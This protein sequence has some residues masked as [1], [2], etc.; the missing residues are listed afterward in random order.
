M[1]G[2]AA[3]LVCAVVAVEAE[4]N[5]MAR[6]KEVADA[7]LRGEVAAVWAEMTPEMQAGIG[8]EEK[9]AEVREQLRALGDE[10]A[11]VSERMYRERGFDVYERIA[12]WT[13]APAPMRTLVSF[14]AD[15]RIGGFW[16]LVQPVAAESRFLDYETRATLRLPFDGAWTVFWGGRTVEDNHHAADRGQRFALDFVVEEDGASHAG[17]P[18]VL[19]SYHCW[20]RPILAPADGVVVRAVGDLPDQAIGASDPANPAGNHVVIDFGRGEYGFLA[21]LRQGSVAVAEGARVAAG[22]EVGRCGNSGNTSEPHLHFHLQTTPILGDDEGLP[23]QFTRYR[24][25]G[26]AVERGE[27]VRGQVIEAE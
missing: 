24:A 6:G 15:G 9:L 13:A 4:A 14:D 10:E 23:A 19:A 17:D 27:P 3:G 25:D 20:D 18:A 2:L 5:D 11:V 12:R 22:T 21:H 26:V 7:F 1:R 16:V 8:S